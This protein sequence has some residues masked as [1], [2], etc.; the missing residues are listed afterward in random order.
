MS[1]G[2]PW[3]WVSRRTVIKHGLG[4]TA[5]E[6]EAGAQS[7]ELQH[8]PFPGQTAVPG[9]PC[10]LLISPSPFQGATLAGRMKGPSWG[11]LATGAGS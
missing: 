10:R 4:H 2:S 8:L 5:G 11:L 7:Q 3:P 6:L 9:L 1:A